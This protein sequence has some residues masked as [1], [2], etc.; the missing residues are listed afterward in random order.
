M[1][2]YKTEIQECFSV[3]ESIPHC[4]KKSKNFKITEINDKNL[5]VTTGDK[6][7]IV[8]ILDYADLLLVINNFESFRSMADIQTFIKKVIP[9]SKMRRLPYAIAREYWKRKGGFSKKANK[10]PKL[11]TLPTADSREL[12]KRVAKLLELT[13]LEPPEGVENPEVTTQNNVQSI[14]RDPKVKAW[15]IRNAKGRC[16]Y[17]EDTAFVKDDGKGYL[18]VHHLRQLANHGTDKIC[19]TVAVCANCHRKLHYAENREEMRKT[20]IK[21]LSSRLK[22]ETVK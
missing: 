22:D 6:S 17:C 13:D 15:V 7:P 4:I 2:V 10:K 11:F 1:S 5:V 8:K 14:K 18:E 16:E 3:G 12:E 9:K 20:L 19:N 21:R